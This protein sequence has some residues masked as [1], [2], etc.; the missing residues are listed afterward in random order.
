MPYFKEGDGKAERLNNNRPID[1]GKPDK[2]GQICDVQPVAPGQLEQACKQEAEGQKGFKRVL[3]LASNE[4]KIGIRCS[5]EG[6]QRKPE[7]GLCRGEIED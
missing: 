5:D 6:A 4:G 2:E 1:H 3:L 7:R